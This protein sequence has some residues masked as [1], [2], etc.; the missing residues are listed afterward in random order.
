MD[1]G[2][3]MQ[4]GGG[5]RKKRRLNPV[6]RSSH[7]NKLNEDAISSSSE[8]SSLESSLESSSKST[9]DPSSRMI[10]SRSSS[11][12]DDSSSSVFPFLEE[13]GEC[14]ITTLRRT[15]AICLQFDLGQKV[16]NFSSEPIVIE[17]QPSW[18]YVIR[19]G[20]LLDCFSL[21]DQEIHI[22]GC[23]RFVFP[24]DA[25]CRDVL[26][27]LSK[28]HRLCGQ[29]S[30]THSMKFFKRQVSKDEL[31]SDSD[32]Q[33]TSTIPNTETTLM[34]DFARFEPQGL[35]VYVHPYSTKRSKGCSIM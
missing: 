32:F 21:D 1:K 2:T 22:E 28:G 25:T 5:V 17:T 9:S 3:P 19:Y 15:L 24:H 27:T 4:D 10:F 35:P 7:P 34:R 26:L 12:S 8:A 29:F 33:A 20:K 14:D 6:D 31:Y 23:R 13:R 30:Q 18:A 11:K 16:A